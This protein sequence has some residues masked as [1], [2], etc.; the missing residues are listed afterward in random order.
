MKAITLNLL[1]S[2]ARQL[3]RAAHALGASQSA[4]AREAFADIDFLAIGRRRLK[5]LEAVTPSSRNS[6]NPPAR[7]RTLG[8]NTL[9]T[10]T[11]T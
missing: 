6:S 1:D 11:S 9:T 2:Q 5:E 7:R 8:A 4:L 3:E 10:R